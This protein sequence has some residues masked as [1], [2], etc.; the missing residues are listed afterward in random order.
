VYAAVLMTTTEVMRRTFGFPQDF[1]RKLIHIGAGMWVFGILALFDTWY[2][3][4]VP[5]ATFI[6]LNF[7]RCRVF[8]AMDATHSTFGTVYFALSVTLLFLVFWRTDSAA[9]HAAIAV[10]GTMAMTWGDALAAIVGQRWGQHTYTIGGTT[11]SWEGSGT[12]FL[13]CSV[14]LF[15]TLLLVPGS[16]FS[17]HSL[18]F[19]LQT[20]VIAALLGA[21]VATSLEALPPAGT[22][23]LWQRVALSGAL[24]V[25]T[26]SEIGTPGKH[27][28]VSQ[29][30]SHTYRYVD[31]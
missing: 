3:G 20:C 7:Y 8:Q 4:V 22:D 10:A 27:V 19:R 1:T 13:V 9:D 30:Q 31:Q 17:P 5:F 23:N 29:F 16:I 15:L 21:L 25:P 18:S 26:D 14:V 12:M 6:V 11:R 24:R 28:Y 2:I